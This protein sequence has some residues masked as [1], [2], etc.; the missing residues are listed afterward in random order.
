MVIFA[1]RRIFS[2]QSDKEINSSQRKNHEPLAAK[3]LEKGRS[4]GLFICRQWIY[5]S[6]LRDLFLQSEQSLKE[7]E[8]KERRNLPR[9]ERS[10]WAKSFSFLKLKCAVREIVQEKYFWSVE[11]QERYLKILQLFLPPLS[12]FHQFSTAQA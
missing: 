4:R 8:K 3:C 5:T 10:C 1:E 6:S 7:A 12:P 2:E 9:R 11:T